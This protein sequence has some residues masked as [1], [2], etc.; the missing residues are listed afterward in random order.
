VIPAHFA[1]E[2]IIAQRE[3]IRAAAVAAGRQDPDL[4]AV[5]RANIAGG[6][7]VE[8]IVDAL[9]TMAAATGI[10][11]MFVDLMYVATTID[12][13]LELASRLLSATRGDGGT[14]GLS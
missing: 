7:P 3:T 10:T 9:E 11:D 6:R 13:M 2:W 8:R 1:P 5:L 12:E 4:P 14:S